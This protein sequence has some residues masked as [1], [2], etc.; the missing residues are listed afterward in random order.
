MKKIKIYRNTLLDAARE[1]DKEHGY[2]SFTWKGFG[3]KW[4]D[5][6]QSPKD[7]YLYCFVIDKDKLTWAMIKYNFIIQYGR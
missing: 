5:Q 6:M 3:L 1:Y 2:H 4:D 7:P